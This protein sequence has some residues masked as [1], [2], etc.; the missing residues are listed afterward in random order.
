MRRSPRSPISTQPEAA[1]RTKQG[2]SLDEIRDAIPRAFDLVEP[3][4]SL[5]QA[6]YRA[7][8]VEHR[9]P[10]P[11][12]IQR[13]APKHGM[14]FG[15]LVREIATESATATTAVAAAVSVG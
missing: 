15:M 8:A 1:S 7:L 13:L 12:V 11:S 10:S 2:Y 3:G 5:T 6:R 14:S 4:H 9:L